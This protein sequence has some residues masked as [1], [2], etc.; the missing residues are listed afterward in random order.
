MVNTNGKKV[1]LN[2]FKIK[3]G[4]YII[5]IVSIGSFLILGSVASYAINNIKTLQDDMYRNALIP[6]T[7]AS[8]VKANLM[9]SKLY[10]TKV[11]SVE[12]K[13]GKRWNK[14]RHVR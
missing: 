10:I 7:Q 8:E 2:N 11:T 6:S 1:L 4:L 14:P 13:D 9:E 12:Y 5:L 3:T